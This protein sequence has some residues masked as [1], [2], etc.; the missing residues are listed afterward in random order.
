MG[1]TSLHKKF[2]QKFDTKSLILRVKT[3]VRLTIKITCYPPFF[4]AIYSPYTNTQKS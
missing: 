4:H 3:I 1:I 2:I